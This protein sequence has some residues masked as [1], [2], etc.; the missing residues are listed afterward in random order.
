MKKS[1]SN[2]PYIKFNTI[3]K[4]INT[5]LNS[6]NDSNN[7]IQNSTFRQ[8]KKLIKNIQPYTNNKKENLTTNLSAPSLANQTFTYYKDKF[9]SS[10]YNDVHKKKFVNS[11]RKNPKNEKLI[12]IINARQKEAVKINNYIGKDT[13]VHN[14]LNQNIC[15]NRWFK[16][17]PKHLINFREKEKNNENLYRR[18]S[19]VF[20]IKK[21]IVF[22][23]EIAHLSV[24]DNFDNYKKDRYNKDNIVRIQD[25]IDKTIK[26]DFGFHTLR[27][28]GLNK[29]LIKKGERNSNGNTYYSDHEEE[30]KDTIITIIN[31]NNSKEYIK[32]R[33]TKNKKKGMGEGSSEKIIFDD[34]KSLKKLIMRNRFKN[35]S[36][37]NFK[38]FDTY[39]QKNKNI[40]SILNEKLKQKN[41][42]KT[43]SVEKDMKLIN[44]NYNLYNGRNK[45]NKISSRIDIISH[46][47]NKINRKLDGYLCK[48]KHSFDKDA[49]K[50]LS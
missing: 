50:Y 22:E 15:G 45:M 4:M 17:F 25:Y 31:H 9:L 49:E 28:V 16:L 42:N 14:F 48:I 12:N 20:K 3:D 41:K 26:E 5:N 23:K 19:N 10:I 2:L 40:I 33:L 1:L 13:F 32:T 43:N 11:L 30:K 27:K 29:A 37:R 24:Y 34:T 6:T 7:N 39:D 35:R 38:D 18:N 46:K 47:L 21:K 36:Q 8:S 44:L